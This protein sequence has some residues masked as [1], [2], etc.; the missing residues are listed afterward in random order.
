MNIPNPSPKNV[1]LLRSLNKG[2]SSVRAYFD[3]KSKDYKT[4]DG[5]VFN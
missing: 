5:R 1:G 3:L 2:E 4:C